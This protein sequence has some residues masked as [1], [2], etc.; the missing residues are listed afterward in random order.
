MSE[1]LSSGTYI[2]PGFPPFTDSIIPRLVPALTV[3]FFL[4]LCFYTTRIIVRARSY[5]MFGPDDLMISCSM[6]SVIPI[7]HVPQEL[8]FVLRF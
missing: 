7:R 3:M 2:P 1:L 6:V 4:A 8:T 5:G